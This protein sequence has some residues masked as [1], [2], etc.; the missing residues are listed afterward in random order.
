MIKGFNHGKRLGLLIRSEG[1][2]PLYTTQFLAALEEESGD[3]FNVRISVLGYLQQGGDPAPF[4]RIRRCGWRRAERLEEWPSSRMR[5]PSCAWAINGEP[6][7]TPIDEA[8]RM[9]D[10]VY[11]RPKK[12]WWMD[13]RPVARILASRIRSI[14]G[15]E[16]RPAVQPL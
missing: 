7:F 1:A 4:D 14:D 5:R 15:V 8:M 10:P 9:T 2:N 16:D 12:Q 6:T 3:P 13:L 11:H